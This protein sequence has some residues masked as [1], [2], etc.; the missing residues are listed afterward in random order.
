[1]VS[2]PEGV[3]AQSRLLGSQHWIKNRLC[4]GFFTSWRSEATPSCGLPSRFFFSAGDTKSIATA[5]LVALGTKFIT[6]SAFRFFD[7]EGDIF[8]VVVIVRTAG[9]VGRA[10]LGFHK[11]TFFR[12]SAVVRMP[13]S[14]NFMRL[15]R[16]GSGALVLLVLRTL[17]GV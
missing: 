9:E 3:S 17:G 2:C 4:V 16:L 14:C 6:L 5:F 11:R 1:M 8:V 10:E 13:I 7:F 15:P 12:S